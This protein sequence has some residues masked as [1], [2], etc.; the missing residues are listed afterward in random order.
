MYNIYI[1]THPK[2]RSLDPDINTPYIYNTENPWFP[3]AVRVACVVPDNISNPL[4]RRYRSPFSVAATYH[5]I[6]IYIY[7]ITPEARKPFIFMWWPPRI[8]K[9]APGPT[10][11]AWRQKLFPITQNEALSFIPSLVAAAPSGCYLLSPARTAV[12]IK[13]D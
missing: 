3:D 7:N 9:N 6:Y 2:S 13:V 8:H 4:T 10:R 5:T 1:G 12:P 11:T